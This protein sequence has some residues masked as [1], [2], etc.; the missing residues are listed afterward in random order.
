MGPAAFEHLN[1]ISYRPASSSA[2]IRRWWCVHPPASAGLAGANGGARAVPTCHYL[3]ILFVM[4]HPGW[5]CCAA[6]FRGHDG[7]D[8]QWKLDYLLPQLRGPLVREEPLVETQ[9]AFVL[10]LITP[11]GRLIESTLAL[12][13]LFRSLSIHPVVGWQRGLRVV[14]P[15]GPPPRLASLPLPPKTVAASCWPI[16]AP[17]AVQSKP[18]GGRKGSP[19][20]AMKLNL[21][22]CAA[23][24]SMLVCCSYAPAGTSPG[25]WSPLAPAEPGVFP[26]AC[27]LARRKTEPSPGLRPSRRRAC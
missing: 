24:G 10:D 20:S 15:T 6:S 4:P 25:W 22:T 26:S 27:T 17:P 7:H 19:D 14:A 8:R 18:D 12:H 23:S 1:R 16:P 2:P 21:V 9:H 13:Q 11:P 5:S 3:Y